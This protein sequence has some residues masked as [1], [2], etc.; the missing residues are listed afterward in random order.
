MCANVPEASLA[1]FTL[2]GSGADPSVDADSY[3]FSP[4]SKQLAAALRDG[5]VQVFATEAQ[6]CAPGSGGLGDQGCVRTG[7]GPKP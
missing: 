1:F 3:D 5:R 4:A 2:Y 6:C 7:G